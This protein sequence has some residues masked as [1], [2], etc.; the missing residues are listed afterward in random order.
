MVI[1]R[2]TCLRAVALMNANERDRACLAAIEKAEMVRPIFL[3]GCASEASERLRNAIHH[4]SRLEYFHLV[5]QYI[6]RR[7][8]D[9]DVSKLRSIYGG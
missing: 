3:L 9:P 7:M 5:D 2:R 1:S 6:W 4:N 8:S